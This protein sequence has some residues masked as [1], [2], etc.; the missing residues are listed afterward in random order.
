MDCAGAGVKKEEEKDGE[1][2]W[3]GC[4]PYSKLT[5]WL[6]FDWQ[7]RDRVAEVG[8]DVIELELW[9][10]EPTQNLKYIIIILTKILQAEYHHLHFTEEDTEV[11][12][13]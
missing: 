12:R 3:R 9:D 10:E 5:P 1:E 4:G 2:G 13:K 8:A 11:Q 7:R 6:H